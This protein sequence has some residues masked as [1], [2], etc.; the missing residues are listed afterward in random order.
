MRLR[1][2]EGECVNAFGSRTGRYSRALDLGTRLSPF[3][4][5]T[6]YF[7]PGLEQAPSGA[8][9]VAIC[10]RRAGRCRAGLGLEV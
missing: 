3:E 10:A 6:L 5:R 8:G 1:A 4:P 7:A 9:E 2:S